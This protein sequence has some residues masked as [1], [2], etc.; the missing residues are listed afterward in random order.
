MASILKVKDKNGNIIEIPA[1]QGSPG[2]DGLTTQIQ[3][4]STVYSQTDGLITLPEFVD[5]TVV[6]NK[7]DTRVIGRLTNVENSATLANSKAHT[8]KNQ[9]TLDNADTIFAQASDVQTLMNDSHT[10][11]NKDV[12]DKISEFDGALTY[13]NKL[14]SHIHSNATVLDKI[15]DDNGVVMYDGAPIGMPQVKSQYYANDWTDG[16]VIANYYGNDILFMIVEPLAE[17]IRIIDVSV[18]YNGVDY[19]YLELILNDILD[20]NSSFCISRK[21]VLDSAYGFYVVARVGCIADNNCSIY[22]DISTLDGRLTE[23]FTIYYEEVEYDG[24]N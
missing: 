8:H 12:L 14:V 1:I 2:K 3:V 20:C 11:G 15:S 19:S 16:V 7:I 5:E 23:G 22:Q 21:S 18:R 13:D 9:T 17:N 4:G 10:H 6:D 24:N